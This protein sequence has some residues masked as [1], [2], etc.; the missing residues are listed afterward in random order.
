MGILTT[1]HAI[2]ESENAGVN[3]AGLSIADGAVASGIRVGTAAGTSRG[4]GRTNIVT[5][6]CSFWR[7]SMPSGPGLSMRAAQK[8]NARVRRLVARFPLPY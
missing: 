8:I 6:P 7:R 2:Q 5:S 1:P 4:F 3:A